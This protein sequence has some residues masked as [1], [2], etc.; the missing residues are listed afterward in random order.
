[1]DAK[2]QVS[3][4]HGVSMFDAAGGTLEANMCLALLHEQGDE[5]DHACMNV[6]VGA[7]LNLHGDPALLAAQ[8]AREE[9]N[10]PNAV[11]VAACAVIGPRRA[12]RARDILHRLIDIFFAVD[13]EDVG[14]EHFDIHTL[15]GD[16]EL[17]AMLTADVRDPKA[18]AMLGGLA[19]RGVSSVFLRYVRAAG[20]HAT[21]D[22]VSAALA[23][24]LVWGPLRR[25]RISRTTAELLPWWFHLFGVLIG[26]SVDARRHE[27]DRF[28]GIPLAELLGA[29][30]LTQT[31]YQAMLGEEPGSSELFTFRTLL[32]L[33]LTNGPGTISAQGAKGAVSADGPETPERVQ[34]NKAMIGFLTH[35]G[36]AHGG[37]G[38]EG[39]AFLLDTFRDAGLLDPGDPRHGLDI[40][41]LAARQVASY[42]R[43]KAEKKASGSLD[44]RKIPGVNHPVF[45]GKPVNHDP[46]EVYVG[47]LFEQRGEYNVFHVYY[48]QIT[49]SLYEAGVSRNVY[50]VNI[51]GVIAALLLKILWRSYR[52][53]AV[54]EKALETAAFTL[55]LFARMIGCAAEIDDH[56]NRGRDMDTRTPA[57]RCAFTA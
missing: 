49:Q 46:R 3:N 55:F 53:G 40:A 4:L 23:A 31:A 35:C 30:S 20:E 33:L 14:D 41:G 37:N 2:T 51:D 6:A 21:A 45:K 28:C 48:R 18:D 1:M 50:C 17:R 19:A 29:R 16:A 42:A 56:L 26:A 15:T 47:E 8:A 34:I 52:N 57:S 27:P 13:L 5:R 22:A 25:K 32:G 38:Y 44:V 54:T 24:T 12:E 7:R 9:G 11:L 43:Y 39:M 36:Y 10:A